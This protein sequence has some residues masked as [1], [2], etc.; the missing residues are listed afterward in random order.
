MK[1]GKFEIF[2]LRE[3]TMSVDGGAT[4]G[5]VPKIRWERRIRPDEKNRIQL[6]I[7]QLLIRTGKANVLIDCGFGTK[8]DER[9]TFM[10]GL[11]PGKK[12]LENLAAHGLSPDDITHVIFTHLHVDHSGGAT[13]FEGG[14]PEN[15]V[16][17]FANAAYY[18]Q[19]GEWQEACAPHEFSRAGY[20]FEN[21]LP[22][23]SAGKIRLIR[24]DQEILE[25]IRVQQTGGHTRFHQMVKIESET[26]RFIFPG[27]IV[28][29]RLHLP[30]G[31]R[32][33]VDLFPIELLESKRRFLDETLNQS[34][35]VAFSHDIRPQFLKLRGSPDNPHL[36]DALSGEPVE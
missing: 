29:S 14:N 24:G 11:G 3:G 36:I 31:W 28:P 23:L 18:A 6:G 33:S 30:P 34:T 10:Y 22:L 25:G 32:S 1:L 8:Q 12:L 27:D 19:E 2:L 9:K 20:V 4:F 17:T 15:V 5:P 13:S 26:A 21:F 7:H 16:P 35:V